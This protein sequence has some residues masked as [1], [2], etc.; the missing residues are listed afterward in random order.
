MKACHIGQT[1]EHKR[2]QEEGASA[3]GTHE[4]PDHV[5]KLRHRA[6]DVSRSVLR[7]LLQRV[8]L[9][10]VALCCALPRNG[11]V[12]YRTTGHQAAYAQCWCFDDNVPEVITITLH[13]YA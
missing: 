11:S 2:E 4:H 7:V 12:W 13:A 6:G 1:F 8:A 10:R 3:T 9:R 5:L